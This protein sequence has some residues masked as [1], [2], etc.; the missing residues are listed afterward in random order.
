[1]AERSLRCSRNMRHWT[2]PSARRMQSTSAQFSVTVTSC[3]TSTQASQ[4]FLN[5]PVLYGIDLTMLL[6]I[7]TLNNMQSYIGCLFFCLPDKL[8]PISPPNTLPPLR[9]SLPVR[10]SVTVDD[11]CKTYDRSDN[12]LLRTYLL[13]CLLTYLLQGAES[14]LRS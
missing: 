9:L 7:T 2:L 11:R 12:N 6:T 5:N 1:M 3:N 13:N 14:F 10:E 4:L 8:R